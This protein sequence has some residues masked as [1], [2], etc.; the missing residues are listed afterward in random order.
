MGPLHSGDANAI[1]HLLRQ[2]QETVFKARGVKM[3]TVDATAR[4]I[5]RLLNATEATCQGGA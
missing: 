1:P 5:D 2:M 3:R 4:P